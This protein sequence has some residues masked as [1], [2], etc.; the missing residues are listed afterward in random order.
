LGSGG[1]LGADGKARGTSRSSGAADRV[2][3]SRLG[4][5]GGVHQHSGNPQ[6][7]AAGKMG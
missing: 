5:F 6:R 1:A 7:S 3:Y 4:G 2:P